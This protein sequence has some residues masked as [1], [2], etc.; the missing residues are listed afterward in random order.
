VLLNALQ[1][2]PDQAVVHVELATQTNGSGHAALA[3]EIRDQ[4]SGFTQE[5]A[6]K[7]GEPFFTTRNVGL[8][9]GLAVTRRIVESHR[10]RLEV[11]PAGEPAAGVVRIT[12]PLA[13]VTGV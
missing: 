13:E 2:S 8:G 3:I 9:L 12:L 4:G 6:Q 10:G 7:A 5:T 1:S 11:V